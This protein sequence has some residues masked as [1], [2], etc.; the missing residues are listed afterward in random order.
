MTPELL[1]KYVNGQATDSQIREVMQ[2]SH[3]KP[4]NM[5]ELE[6]LQRLNDAAIWNSAPV[7]DLAMKQKRGTAFYR[8]AAAWAV[9]AS[10]ILLAGFSASLFRIVSQEEKTA[11]SVTVPLGQRTEL[12]LDDGTRIWLNSGSRLDVSKGYNAKT[13]EVS[14]EGEAYF[15][16]AKD[17]DRPF[18]VHTQNYCVRV[19]GTEFNLSSYADAGEWSVSLVNGKVEVQGDNDETVVLTPHTKLEQIDGKLVRS[20]FSDNDEFLWREGIVSFEDASYAEIFS[21]LEKYFHISFRVDDSKLLER[22]STCKFMTSDGIECIMDILL[23]GENLSY[24]FDMENRI[25]SVK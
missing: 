23:L 17:A 19:L 15:S 2:W 7:K 4:E 14:L 25:V 13:R 22:R 16:V 10:L 3:E 24:D 8:R 6:A 9:A 12:S 11:F 1:N 20:E 18:L 21:K 5:R